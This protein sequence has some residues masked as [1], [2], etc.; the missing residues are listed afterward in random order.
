MLS[1][2]VIILKI[3]I[4]DPQSGEVRLYYIYYLPSHYEGLVEVYL[5]EE[6]GT[7][8]DDSWTQE[9]GEVVCRQLGFSDSKLFK[10]R[11]LMNTSF[12]TECN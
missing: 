9:D 11:Q 3:I 8:S 1:V 12:N 4:D 2:C 10:Y 5:S 7:V 6:W